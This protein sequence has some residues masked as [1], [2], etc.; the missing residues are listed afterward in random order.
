MFI[1]NRHLGRG[2]GVIEIVVINQKTPIECHLPPEM[3]NLDSISDKR[4][5]Y[6][7][8]L[9]W[10]QLRHDFMTKNPYNILLFYNQI[11]VDCRHIFMYAFVFT[12]QLESVPISKDTFNSFFLYQRFQIEKFIDLGTYSMMHAEASRSPHPSLSY[13]SASLIIQQK[14]RNTLRTKMSI[15]SSS[16]LSV[17]S[18]SRSNI[19]QPIYLFLSD[20]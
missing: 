13:L 17:A 9:T 19:K 1:L 6:F 12:L 7:F 8:P 10:I 4:P 3:W 20:V 2:S 11:P 18:L 14:R 5:T 16:T 15:V